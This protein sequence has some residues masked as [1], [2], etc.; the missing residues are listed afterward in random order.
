MT[1]LHEMTATELAARIRTGEVSSR[2]VIEAHL[3]RIGRVNRHV[4]AITRVFVEAA[5]SAA[6]AA[7]GVRRAGR[8]LAPLH[9]VPFTVKESIDCLGTPTTHGL[10]ALRTA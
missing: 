3:E 10:P 4:H 5:R 1:A 6:D 9:G 8:P 7:D 2:E